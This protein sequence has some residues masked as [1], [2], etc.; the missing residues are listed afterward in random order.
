MVLR[1]WRVYVEVPIL[2]EWVPASQLGSCSREMIMGYEQLGARTHYVR[3]TGGGIG[4][5]WVR[6][7][8]GGSKG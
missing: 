4:L 5:V 1:G 3:G 8:V 2:H 6:G 7:S